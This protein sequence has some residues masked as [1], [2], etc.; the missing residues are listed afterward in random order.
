MDALEAAQRAAIVGEAR[1]WIRTPYQHGADRKKGGVDCLMLLVR[2]FADTGLIEPIDPR[3]YSKTWFLH[4]DS[5]MYLDGVL[6]YTRE[7]FTPPQPG[8]I[9]LCKIGRLFAHGGIVTTWPKVIHAFAQARM[10]LED[11]VGLQGKYEVVEKRF[12]SYWKMR[13][14][15]LPPVAPQHDAH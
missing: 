6:K 10:V 14:S 9:V 11:N 5:E 15:G 7:I 13:A 2:V 4:R 3:P 8:D 12:F 1:T